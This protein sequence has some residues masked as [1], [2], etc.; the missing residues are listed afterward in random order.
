MH[1]I[2]LDISRELC[3]RGWPD[4]VYIVDMKG[5]EG[6]HFFQDLSQDVMIQTSVL[7][8]VFAHYVLDAVHGDGGD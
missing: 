7:E 1:I 5:L 4:I 8:I 3:Q 6:I 2:S